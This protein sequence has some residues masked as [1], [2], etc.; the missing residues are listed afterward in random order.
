MTVQ[1]WSSIGA[2]GAPTAVLDLDAADHNVAEMRRR[3]SG[4]PIRVASKSIRVRGLIDRMLREPGYAGVLAYSAAEALWLARSGVD[5]V[6]IAY[7]TVDV[8]TVKQVAAD[9]ELAARITFM[10]DLPEHVR[11]LDSAGSAHPL[12]VCLDV[13]ASLPV[14]KALIGAHRS[15]VH[16]PGQAAEFARATARLNGVRLV[17]L[18]FYDA[19][20]AGVQDTN[21]AVRL[22][23][24]RSVAEL[25]ERR[26]QLWRAVASYASIE[27]VNAGGT[28][29]LHL[30]GGSPV[31][32]FAAGSGLFAPTLFDR[33]DGADL[34]PAAYFASP[35][36][37]K[38]RSDVAVT[39]SGGYAASGASGASRAPR[40]VHPEGLRYFA[41]EGAGE[42]QTP[43]RGAAAR[44]LA[45]GDAVWFRHAKAGE[46]CER[47]DEILL[48]RG[49]SVVDRLPTYRGEGHN[50][51]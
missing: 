23:K 7:P 14:G 5:D 21:A 40:P 50:F 8:E 48:V 1:L 42:V 30:V 43:L 45:V 18:M 34:R 2:I 9:S 41:Q 19:Q 26:E 29:S 33:Y 36:V 24:R 46:M 17:G 25:A 16:G 12:R 39:F 27:V 22:L 35:V 20:V 49:G 51:G 44:E 11:L 32:E 3:A 15:S 6:L 10:A 28:G 38:P 37:R 31:T 47:F 4:T 13:D